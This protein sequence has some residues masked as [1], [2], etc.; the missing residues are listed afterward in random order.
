MH[1]WLV[2]RSPFPATSLAAI[3][4]CTTPWSRANNRFPARQLTS[5]RL[6][7]HRGPQASC[8]VVF[9]GMLWHRQKQG[10]PAIGRS[11]CDR[12]SPSS[13][14]AG[15]DPQA[16][17]KIYIQRFLPSRMAAPIR[18]VSA[19]IGRGSVPARRALGIRWCSAGF[20]NARFGIGSV[21]TSCKVHMATRYG[22]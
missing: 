14:R 1:G 19:T 8:H 20:S 11:K 13:Q 2:R 3:S 17:M 10:L 4:H 6:R 9:K 15:H 7:M 21:R 5:P 22:T 18:P 16:I 12:A